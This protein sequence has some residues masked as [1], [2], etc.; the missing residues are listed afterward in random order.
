V[1]VLLQNNSLP[2]EFNIYL[3]NQ[4]SRHIENANDFWVSRY[5]ENKAEYF[6]PSLIR[7]Y[8]EERLQ[9]LKIRTRT[10]EDSV[11]RKVLERSGLLF[12][13]DI[14]ILWFSEL[15]S[16]LIK[17]IFK[18]RIDT[19]LEES[20]LSEIMTRIQ[21]MLWE[22]NLALWMVIPEWDMFRPDNNSPTPSP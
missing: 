19:D 12:L 13:W 3:N 7:I 17:V 1:E 8:W 15:E 16:K 6:L 20:R 14:C 2:W 9:Y 11:I 5:F 4:Q 18:G 22:Y 21:N 10:I